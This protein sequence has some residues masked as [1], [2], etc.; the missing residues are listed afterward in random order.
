MAQKAAHFKCAVFGCKK[1]HT[2]VFLP[3]SSEE[4]KAKWISFIYGRNIPTDVPKFLYVCAKHFPSDCFLN[5]GQFKAG[6][7]SRLR[8]KPGSVPTLRAEAPDPEA[9]SVSLLHTRLYTGPQV[10][11]CVCVFIRSPTTCQE[12]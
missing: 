9:V 8:L 1:G 4:V 7:A 6:F 11:V 12:E 10:S 3:P 2:S 5:E